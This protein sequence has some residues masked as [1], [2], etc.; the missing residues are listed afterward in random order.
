[1]SDPEVRAWM[2]DVYEQGVRVV[3]AAG[4]AYVLPR[5]IGS[6]EQRI[7]DLRQPSWGSE[8][9]GG[10]DETPGRRC[11]RTSTTG[12]ARSRPSGSTARS[13][14]S[15]KSTGCPLR[16]RACSTN[17]P[18]SAQRAGGGQAV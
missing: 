13:C 6:I 15:A 14:A 5:E 3:P 4:V 18:R 10:G 16:T 2:A 1:M 7:N 11:G 9:P 8:I 17:S 12:R